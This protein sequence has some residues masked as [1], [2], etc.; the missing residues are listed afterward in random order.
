MMTQH[1]LE[2]LFARNS[3]KESLRVLRYRT[4]H[5]LLRS[6]V[7][8]KQFML[9]DMPLLEFVLQRG[10]LEDL[11]TVLCLPMV[12]INMRFEFH[13]S[14][15]TA[16]HLVV[17]GGWSDKL[18]ILLAHSISLNMKNINGETALMLAAENND[19]MCTKLLLAH[20]AKVNIVD[21]QGRSA[22][23]KA[24]S[25]G[26]TTC[27]TLLLHHAKIDVNGV[28][29]RYGESNT[30]LSQAVREGHCGCVL[31]LLRHPT[32]NIHKH[33]GLR[34]PPLLTAMINMCAGLNTPDSLTIFTV[35]MAWEPWR[36]GWFPPITYYCPWLN[37]HLED[38]PYCRYVFK[39]VYWTPSVFQHWLPI[40]WSFFFTVAL[41]N[42]RP[43]KRVQLPNEIIRYIFTYWRS[44]DILKYIP[45]RSIID[46]LIQ[47]FE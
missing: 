46:C 24:A 5:W 43:E 14:A 38:Q 26:A 31:A 4:P 18:S 44:N 9:G 30:P 32:I 42:E 20:G 35:L 34:H 11:E 33:K 45:R 10:D 37:T 3:I 23:Y 41:C 21:N 7:N 15:P 2:G 19:V 1:F 36:E 12:D 29:W 28:G 25:L 6:F 8:K 40:W 39:A 47:D 27:L 22:L 16:L 13:D 17:G